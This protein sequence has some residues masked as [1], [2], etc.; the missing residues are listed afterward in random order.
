MDMYWIVLLAGT[1]IVLVMVRRIDMNSKKVDLAYHRGY[2]QCLRDINLR[3]QGAIDEASN[4]K[5]VLRLF[6]RIVGKTL[7]YQNCP[8]SLDEKHEFHTW[9]DGAEEALKNFEL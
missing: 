6:L 9:T 5:P 2:I 8:L 3:F 7:N 1:L 4:P